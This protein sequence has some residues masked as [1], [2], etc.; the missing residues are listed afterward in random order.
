MGVDQI[1]VERVAIVEAEDNPPVS[2]YGNGPKS[3]KISAKWMEP[4]AREVHV[5]HFFRSFE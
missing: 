3:L 2:A 1:D 4:Q 5:L